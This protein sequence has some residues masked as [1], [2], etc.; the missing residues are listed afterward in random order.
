MTP[1]REGARY[2]YGQGI[3][4][5]AAPTAATDLDHWHW[6]VK[7]AGASEFTISDRSATAELKLPTSM[8]W[9][10]AQVY[11]SLYDED[12]QVVAS[13]AP[14]T[15]EVSTLPAVTTITAATD[16]PAYRA[17][18]VARL[19][20]TQQPQT[21]ETHF[22]WYVRKTGEEFYTYIP[23][24]DAADATLPITADLDGAS[25]LVRLFDDA[26]AVIAE[27]APVPLQ[28]ADAGP[29]ATTIAARLQPSTVRYAAKRA[30]LQVEVD[31][32]GATPEG[33]V[34]VTVGGRTVARDVAVDEAGAATVRLPKKLTPGRHRV[35]AHFRPADD[36][37]HAASSSPATVLKVERAVS[38]VK[39]VVAKVVRP[40]Q[41][42]R[43]AITV[44]SA[45]D[46]RGVVVIRDGARR[47]VKV[48]LDRAGRAVVRLPRLSV[49]KHRLVVRYQGDRLHAADTARAVLRV[50]R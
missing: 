10:G 46:P 43:V 29:G 35:V 13:S 9:N 19:S 12:H 1:N 42:A 3:T 27:S 17:G 28:V 40:A 24:S 6:F 2:L 23:G 44:A 36:Q 4:L 21:D 22:H 50:R 11:A 20:S 33:S 37:A 41:R 8:S 47:L 48:R 39:A 49:G 31:A 14:V 34:D 38:R 7:P 25:V 45:A 5:T 32:D 18:D 16:R 26:H 30:A 15:L